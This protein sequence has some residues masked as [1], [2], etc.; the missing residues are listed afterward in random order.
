MNK[1]LL[2][3]CGMTGMFTRCHA[4]ILPGR[5]ENFFSLAFLACL[6]RARCAIRRLARSFAAQPVCGILLSCWGLEVKYPTT[7]GGSDA[8]AISPCAHLVARV[9]TLS[10][11]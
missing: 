7:P 6:H 4:P 3:P 1:K 5:E 10:T 9:P 11:I 8:S 2:D